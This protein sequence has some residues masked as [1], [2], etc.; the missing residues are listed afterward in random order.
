LIDQSP[1]Q[2]AYALAALASTAEEQK[3]AAEANRLSD[4]E[5]DLA[6]VSALQVAELH[7]PLDNSTTKALNERIHK[8]N[9]RLQSLQQTVN[10]LTPLAASPENKDNQ[11]MQQQLEVAQARVAL[12][13]DALDDAR[14]DLVNAG[15][16][17]QAEIKQELEDHDA[18]QHKNSA[19]VVSPAAK[20]ASFGLGGSLLSQFQTWR[21]LRSN[22]ARLLQAQQQA[23]AYAATL[24]HKHEAL[25]KGITTALG[26]YD[27]SSD[28]S[29]ST[30]SGQPARSAGKSVV[31]LRD[32]AA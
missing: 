30:D 5:V 4:H 10:R 32:T 14:E 29:P 22:Q 3:L 7:P 24:T 12:L 8:L 25:A 16:D 20:P 21:R 1:L 17:P 11:A 28:E 2:T 23:D 6:F 9:D 31:S 19:S 18:L 27:D 26:D 15:G 13:Q